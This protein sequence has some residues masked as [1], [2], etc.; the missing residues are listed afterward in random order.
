MNDFYVYMYLRSY[1]SKHGKS[2]SPYYIGKGRG[3]RVLNSKRHTP[4]PSNPDNIVYF[5]TDLSEWDAFQLEMLLIHRF[6]RI[7]IGT[8]SLRNFTDGGEGYRGAKHSDEHKAHISEWMKAHPNAG[9]FTSDPRP[10]KRGIPL[11]EV[12]K[13]KQSASWTEEKRKASAERQRGLKH[14]PERAE[15]NRLAQLGKKQSEETKLKRSSSLAQ[16]WDSPERRAKLA[17]LMAAREKAEGSP[18]E[19]RNKRRRER[20]AKL[21]AK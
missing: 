15:K 6:G 21:A 11:P 8:G 3:S 20:Y 5:A 7:D 14:S 17:A 13:A 4:R 19:R 18:S 1:D 12:Q 2:G 9:Q 16:N 10:W